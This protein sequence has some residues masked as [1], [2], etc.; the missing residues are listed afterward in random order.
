VPSPNQAVPKPR[1][2]PLEAYRPL[3][4]LAS[5]GIGLAIVVVLH[6]VLPSTAANVLLDR[7][8][9]LYPFSVQNGMWLAF[10]VGCGELFVRF[11]IGRSERNQLTLRYL[12]EDERTVLQAAD[13]GEIY[14][15][16][17]EN[18]NAHRCFLPRLIQRAILQFQSS[19]SIDQA[20][21]LLNTSVE[22]YLHE[23]DLR[24]SM[25]RYFTWFIPTLGFIGTVIGIGHALSYAG[26]PT[27]AQDPLLLNEVTRRL[28]ISFNG[29]FLALVMAAVLIFLMHLAQIREET[30]LN[31]A[32]QYC[33]D[34]LINRLFVTPTSAD[35]SLASQVQQPLR[36]D[37]APGV[38]MPDQSSA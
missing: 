13:L 12:P 33:L 30:A 9:I 26:D 19:R 28:S 22:L 23:V 17:R 6:H 31:L 2:A 16:V 3:I 5:L 21:S 7:D 35:G 4:A 34:N 29:T 18:R 38:R 24:Y 27:H 37:R 32:G 11:R 10:L 25:L 36:S 14:R 8:G 15:R 1:V 20:S